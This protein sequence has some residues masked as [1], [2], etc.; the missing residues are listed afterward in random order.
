MVPRGKGKVF[1][2]EEKREQS[3]QKS[4]FFKL[5]EYLIEWT[6]INQHQGNSTLRLFTTY[7]ERTGYNFS[8]KIDKSLHVS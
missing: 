2:K 8:L 6:K 4:F 7:P 3:N 1:E 5:R